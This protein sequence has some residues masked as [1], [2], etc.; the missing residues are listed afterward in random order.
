LDGGTD[1]TATDSLS[2]VKDGGWIIQSDGTFGAPSGQ[3][4][5]IP[6]SIFSKA[7][8][9]ADRESL[10]GGKSR[11]EF[12][13]EIGRF[14]LRAYGVEGERDGQADLPSFEN[15][16]FV[17]K[18]CDEGG[19]FFWMKNG[20]RMFAEGQDSGGGGDVWGGAA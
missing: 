20:E 3:H 17:G 18:A 1:S 13:K 14:L 2:F 4:F 7:P 15:A 8:V 16:K 6:R 11:G 9:G 10:Q 19:V 12:C 5:D